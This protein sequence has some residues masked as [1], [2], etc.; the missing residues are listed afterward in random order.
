MTAMGRTLRAAAA[1][2]TAAATWAA[3][4]PLLRRAFGTPH[5]DVR[6]LGRMIAPERLAGPAGLLAHLGNGAMFGAGFDRLGGRG[7]VMAVLAAE[8]ENLALWPTMFVVDRVHPDVR[9]GVWPPLA[10]DGRVFA[11]EA[12]SHAVFGLVLGLLLS[13]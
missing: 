6:L 3:V 5:T 13:D 1:G 12:A 8:A 11:H 9:S 7:P 2:I 4:D 10:R